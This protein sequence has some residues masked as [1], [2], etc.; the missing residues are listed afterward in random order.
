MLRVS[1]SNVLEEDIEPNQTHIEVP[2]AAFA[3][4]QGDYAEYRGAKRDGL[5]AGPALARDWKA[6]PPKELWR[7][8]IGGGYAGFVVQGGVIVTIEQRRDQEA[9]VCY[10]TATGTEIWANTYSHGRF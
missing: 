7:Q 4:M 5:I 10:D 1:K 3:P 2:S 9:V 8:R 6:H